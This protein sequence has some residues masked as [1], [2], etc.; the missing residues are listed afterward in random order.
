MA[1]LI[2]PGILETDPKHILI[3]VG[4]GAIA[5]LCAY[6][7]KPVIVSVLAAVLLDLLLYLFVY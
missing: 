7:K 4:G 6:R 1:S 2:F 3:G 5:V